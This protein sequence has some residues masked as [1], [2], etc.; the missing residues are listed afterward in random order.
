MMNNKK[1]GLALSGG[2]YRAAAYH[3]GTF[4]ALKEMDLLDK[5]DVISSNSGGSI[6]NGC[7]GLYG[8]DYNTFETKLISSLQ[9]GVIKRVFVSREFLLAFGYLLASIWNLCDPFFRTPLWLNIALVAIILPFLV[10]AQF[11]VLPLNKVLERIYNR[12]F[13]E[14]KTL[15]DLT[16]KHKTVINASNFD[17]ARVFTFE[18]SRLTDSKYT[19]KNANPRVLFKH[20]KFP[21]S[22]AVVAS[23]CVP[24]AFTPV[25]IGKEFFQNEND[26]GKI[27]PRLV[28]GGIYD[29]QGIHKLTQKNS[30]CYCN[31]VIVSDA[32][33]GFDHKKKFRNQIS[34]LT[35]TSDIF[36]E[37]I[38]NVQMMNN[39]YN[40]QCNNSIVAYQS[41]S[42]DLES[43]LSEFVKMLKNKHIAPEVIK[44]H[45]IEKA[46]IDNQ[47]WGK[48]EDHIKNR[49]GLDV[50]IAKG[51]SKEELTK[52]R[53]IKTG[54]SW[55]RQW[56]IDLLVK[57]AQAITELQVKLF[58]PHLLK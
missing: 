35:R 43:S 32:G 6:T 33:R 17:T 36:M 20:G 38:K 10:F 37:R 47:N 28:D 50:I 54:L 14:K 9:K 5:I 34:L 31:Y 51:C 44:A 2:G 30:T 55:F 49:I 19:N 7:Y 16:K 11:F 41:L 15:G 8:D 18:E 45:E 53:G 40:G 23:T 24:F 26:Y 22:R 25:T 4:R 52:A 29:N 3:I 12:L 39:L 1:I 21:V 48:I 57:H 58:L 46:D 27:N 13:F 56:K 42:F